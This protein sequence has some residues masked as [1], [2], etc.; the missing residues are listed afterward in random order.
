[1]AKKMKGIFNK[2]KIYTIIAVSTAIIVIVFMLLFIFLF[3]FL[4]YK[5]LVSQNRTGNLN[6]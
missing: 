2:N 3:D 5:V 6:P 4:I 1:M